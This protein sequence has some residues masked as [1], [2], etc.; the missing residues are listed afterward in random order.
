MSS[1]DIIFSNSLAYWLSSYND[2]SK[3]TLQNIPLGTCA[4][5]LEVNSKSKCCN[6]IKTLIKWTITR[7]INILPWI[8]LCLSETGS[9]LAVSCTVPAP[10]SDTPLWLS[11][12]LWLWR[13][14]HPVCVHGKSC[15]PHSG[16]PPTAQSSQCHTWHLPVHMLKWILITKEL[17]TKKAGCETAL[18]LMGNLSF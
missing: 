4:L 7:L 10:V 8:L 12:D 14:G 11:G 17:V 16:P 15:V 3:I 9:A 6:T 5:W 13:G 18:F 2:R 1:L